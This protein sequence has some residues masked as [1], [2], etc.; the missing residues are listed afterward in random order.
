MVC[1]LTDPKWRGA[2]KVQLRQA[3]AGCGE[4]QGTQDDKI[5]VEDIRIGSS[6]RLVTP[7]ES[8]P[9]LKVP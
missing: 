2:G 9:R 3:S 8:T 4:A 5:A 6:A 1:T 7:V